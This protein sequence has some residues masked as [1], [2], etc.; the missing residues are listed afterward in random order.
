MKSYQLFPLIPFFLL[1]SLCRARA[2]LLELL[3]IQVSQLVDLWCLTS[4]DTLGELGKSTNSCPVADGVLRSLSSDLDDNDSWV[5]WT[6]IVLAVAEVTNPCLECWR[7]VLVHL[8]AVGLDLGLAGNRGPLAGWGEE[9][10]V[11]VWVG[12]EVV[13][14]AGLGVG[15]EDDV[16]TVALLVESLAGKSLEG[17]DGCL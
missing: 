13:G 10:D 7:V 12:L 15:V 2:P 6:A 14:L 1:D 5:I 9:A 16:D 11:D 3:L 4:D 8:L 17:F